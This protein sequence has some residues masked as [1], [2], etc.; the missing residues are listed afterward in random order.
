MK[1]VPRSIL[2]LS[3]L[4]VLA[5]F[6]MRPAPV[7][8][9]TP[10]YVSSSGGSDANN[11]LSQGAPFRTIAKVN[12]LGLSSGDQVLF[13]CGD[14]WRGE[15]LR[16][17]HSGASGSPITFSYYPSNCANKPI[18]SGAQPI[19]GWSV[20]SGNIYVADL[21]AGA[22]AA[23]F[24]SGT[25]AGINQLF[26]SGQRLTIGRWPNANAAD[27]GYAVVASGSG[28]QI[29]VTNLSGNWT[30]AG[31]HI[32]AYRHFILN[33]KITASSSNTY[34]LNSSAAC[35]GGCAGWGAWLDNNLQTLDQDGEWYY[36]S[37]ANKVYLY[38]TG[39][40]PDGQQIEGSA[41]I[42]G[43]SSQL[44]GIILGKQLG[45]S[46]SHIIVDN[47]EIKDWFANGITT[48][49]QFISDDSIDV[50]I[51]NNLIRDV[52]NTGILLRSYV[53]PP[54]QSNDV[55]RGGSNIQVLANTI[56]GANHTGIYSY[57]RQSTIQDNVIRNI[58]LIPNLGQSGM[59]CDITTQVGCG[60]FGDGIQIVTDADG[61][62]S[63]NHMTVQYNR[64]Q[65]VGYN[66]M[67]V[68][69]YSNHFDNNVILQPCQSKS[70]C[71]G[72]NGYGS[73]SVPASH[74]H[75]DSVSN[76]IIVDALSNTNG[77]SSA[78]R[79]LLAVGIEY[80][81]YLRN[82][83]TSGNTV[84]HSAFDGIR[85]QDATGPI[86]NNTVYNNVGGTLWGNEISIV[87]SDS[88]VPT[89]TGNII[90]HLNIKGG[91]LAVQT[92]SQLG[93][94]DQ[95][96]FYNASGPQHI[97]LNNTLKSLAEWRTVSGK[98]ANS[99]ERISSTLLNSQ[100]FYNDT[101]APKNFPLSGNYTDL[102]GHPILGGS[103]TLQPF[104]SQVLI[105]GGSGITPTPIP[106]PTGTP[107]PTGPVNL[108]LPF[109]VK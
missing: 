95:N 37:A 102:D 5:L 96:H 85:Y 100:I 41:V 3:A 89:H 45:Q 4:A 10:Y 55:W 81:V 12:G 58:A 75:D 80:Q 29:K 40:D 42:N 9:G 17:T 49:P 36:D 13:K 56:D 105:P 23:N 31:I 47:F 99:T 65:S 53:P 19:T 11:G 84:I 97:V 21:S 88:Q 63:S 14:T 104:T 50:I 101:K 67:F 66:G 92:L 68:S 7:R 54:P 103:I 1:H 34:T 43:E 106:S 64:I 48:P 59:G 22:N 52:D 93:T 76:N 25:T 30:G 78:N 98:D 24:P 46:V 72:V 38:S 82:M 74:T 91:T 51:R 73:T 69:G 70:D 61:A 107:G 28:T 87:K 32:R 39:G 86:Q 71:A 79:A 108:F 90:V 26:R 60:E 33:R 44:G 20:S 83:T 16:I 2:I 94:S 35:D 77:S 62:Y 18:I 15:I 109:V 6:A 57:A 27:G 8:A